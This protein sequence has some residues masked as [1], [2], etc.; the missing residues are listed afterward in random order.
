MLTNKYAVTLLFT[1][2]KLWF[3]IFKLWNQTTQVQ[4]LVLLTSCM[5]LCM[6]IKLF[7]TQFPHLYNGYHNSTYYL[8][9]SV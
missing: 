3:I 6:I 2:E 7:D 5:I 4:T 9:D 8:T 1:F